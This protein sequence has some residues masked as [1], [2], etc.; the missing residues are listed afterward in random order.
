MIYEC[1]FSFELLLFLFHVS[2]DRL[3]FHKSG[4]G[5][6]LEIFLL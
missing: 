1:N 3:G 6:D 2:S 4:F 5:T